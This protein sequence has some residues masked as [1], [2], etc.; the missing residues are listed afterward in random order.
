VLFSSHE[1]IFGFL[2]LALLAFHL[3]RIYFGGRA[4]LGTV[5]AASLFF[6]GWWNPPFLALLAGSMAV[7]YMLARSLTRKP[8]GRPLLVGIILNLGVLGYFKYRNFFLENLGYLTGQSWDL[9]PIFV[10]LAISFFTFQQIALLV[11][12]RDR[13]VEIRDPADFAAF[14]ALFPQLIAGPIVLF[15]EIEEQ[16]KKLKEGDG[17]GLEL[18]GAGIVV[19]ALG[20]F[21][22]VV[23]ADSIA[24]YA[25]TAFGVAE[26]LTFLEAWAGAIAY[27][28]QLYFDFS[29]YSDMAVGLGLMLGIFLPINFNTPFRATSMV[30]FW[31][32]WHITMTRF[33]MMYLYSPIALALTRRSMAAGYTGG[34]AFAFAVGVPIGLTFL[35]SGLW[36][37]AA[38]TFIAFGAVNAVGL[39]ANHAWREAKLPT[40]PGPVGWLLTMLTVVVSFVY[41]RAESMADAHAILSAMAAP[42][43]IMLPNWLSG[44]A[45]RVDLPWRTLDFF[46]T[47]TYTLRLT[48]WIALLFGL[49]MMPQNPAAEP[50]KIRSSWLNAALAA[51]LLLLALGLLDRP[52][53]FIYFQF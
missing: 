51:G 17:P 23:L 27:S 12:V 15:R 2:P 47:G 40:L 11:D 34:T 6:Y 31:K 20:L 13:R 28:L 29:G 43:E 4:A 39:I 49:S 14:V 8:S 1:F 26:Q 25:D 50:L 22:K 7:N 24:P 52:Q 33:F 48:V 32:R 38:W 45:E 9:E 3:T 37:G 30:D 44:W 18:F 19:F 53:A 42:Q 36:H 21:K 35:L 16:F 5:A 10:P 46:A 41:F